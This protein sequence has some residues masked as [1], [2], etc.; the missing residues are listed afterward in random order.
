MIGPI[1]LFASLARAERLLTYTEALTSAASKNGVAVRGEL[2]WDSAEASQQA[3][4]G[5]FDPIYALSGTYGYRT[6]EE[7]RDALPVAG[8]ERTWS[9]ST[10]ITGLTA[11]GTTYTLSA[12]AGFER[13]FASGL[14][15]L[16]DEE[17]EQVG[18]APYEANL[19]VYNSSLTF[20]LSQ[21]LLR[22]VS[23]SFNLQAI[24]MARHATTMAERTALQLRQQAMADTALWY[25]T[26]VHQVRVHEIDEQAVSA[27][28]EAL[29]VATAQV[30]ARQLAPVERTR[31][32]A[33]WVLAKSTARASDM[34]VTQARDEL[35]VQMG[36]T[37]GA[38]IVPATDPGVPPVFTLDVEAVATKALA[39]NPELAVARAAVE[40]QSFALAT[41]RHARLPAL[42]AV[43]SAGRTTGN[44]VTLSDAVAGLAGEAGHPVVTLGA[45]LTVP[46]GNRTAAGAAR[47]AAYDRTAAEN[48]VYELE[49]RIRAQVA[50]QVARLDGARELVDAA[51]AGVRLAEETLDATEALAE[52]RRAIPK[53]LLEART[54]LDRA[55][56]EAVRARTEWR[57]AHTE[58]ARLQA[59]LTEE[60]P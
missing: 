23:M 50:Y 40:M 49:Q 59:G 56:I 51:D 45:V 21:H 18:T 25:W 32:E 54:L 34:L 29:R 52:A 4:R 20:T 30:E 60:L 7:T 22:G 16:Y 36:E 3:A 15:P 55:R 57:L 1:V 26:W 5:L 44:Q 11:T 42:D 8:T 6:F 58:L 43:A 12:L 38:A 24:R 2:A 14:Q 27:A 47:A 39:D 17:G 48:T 19:A 37:P 9:G 46:L 53:D 31:L 41:A 10:W 35:L 13:E 33:A 28:E